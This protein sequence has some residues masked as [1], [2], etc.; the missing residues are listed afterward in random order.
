M[1]LARVRLSSRQ[2]VFAQLAQRMVSAVDVPVVH[3]MQ[4]SG[5]ERLN[6]RWSACHL[7]KSLRHRSRDPS[8]L[9]TARTS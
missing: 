2:L 9:V 8:C 6:R 3:G 4:D 5:F 7:H 1:V